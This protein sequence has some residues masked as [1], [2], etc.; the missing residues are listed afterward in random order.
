MKKII[1]ILLMTVLVLSCTSCQIHDDGMKK[2]TWPDHKLAKVLPKPKSMVG[3]VQYKKD[4][5]VKILV[6]RMKKKEYKD[7]IEQCKKA[8][9][10]I[11]K[12]KNENLCNLNH[13]DGYGL[14]LTYE[15][16]S[17]TMLIDIKEK[18]YMVTLKTGI[19]KNLLFN[20][21]SI[22]LYL[23]DKKI[24]VLEHGRADTFKLEL[25]KGRHTLKAEKEEDRKIKGKIKFDVQGKM[26]VKY[27]IL[28]SR[29]QIQIKPSSAEEGPKKTNEGS[30][31][32]EEVDD[33]VITS[34]NN[35][36]FASLLSLKNPG[37]PSVEIFVNAHLGDIIKFNGSIAFV[38]KH[39]EN[40]KKFDY[41][42]Y[43]EDYNEEYV[44]GPNFQIENVSYDELYITEEQK[45]NRLSAGI[46][47][48]ITAEIAGYDSSS[49][50]IKIKPLS[51]KIR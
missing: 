20:R 47:I 30:M 8:G 45:Q 23:D 38:S 24:G 17:R 5:Q 50:T 25:K 21:Y 2:L 27:D 42:I 33:T 37:D 31:E 13:K 11:L 1:S 32:I 9:F 16:D 26:E 43:S 29:S 49:Q 44:L 10:E 34:E 19:D 40:D 51:I 4:D 3:E 35:E 28:C 12:S 39:E 46:N 7:Y 48:Q 22:V 18:T 6:G 15:E 41:L 14:T 36:E